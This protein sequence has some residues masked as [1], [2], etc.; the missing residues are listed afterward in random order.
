[1]TKRFDSCVMSKLWRNLSTNRIAYPKIE[2][3]INADKIYKRETY[4]KTKL[5]KNLPKK[6]AKLVK[7][8]NKT[9]LP[10]SPES[11][12]RSL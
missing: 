5:I 8:N 1:M 11:S 12:D 2:K 9:H 3:K 6:K 10:F 7:K 4:K